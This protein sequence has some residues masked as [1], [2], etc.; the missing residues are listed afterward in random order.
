M[1]FIA[2]GM[3]HAQQH[4]TLT[5]QE[6]AQGWQLLFDGS[7]LS[8]WHSYLAKA[9]GKD[10][11]VSDGA[12]LLQKQRSDPQADFQ[13]LVTDAEFG[14]FDLKLSWKMSPCADS[15]VMFYVHESPKY[16][17]TYETGPEM[18]IADLACTKPDSRVLYERSGDLFDLIS[19]D[20]EW[21]NEAGQWNDFEII[22]DHGHVQFFQNGHKVIDTQLWNEDWKRLVARTKFKAWPDFATFREG[23]ISLQATEDKGVTPIRLWFRDIK[24][25]K[26]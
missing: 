20:V 6:K 1:S 21:V 4:N 26:L 24:I 2:C 9:P 12:I 7:S 19:S 25:R 23:H 15:G 11:K 10:W 22:A 5:A 17:N 8:G 16:Q 13:D 3:V 14:N 18:Q